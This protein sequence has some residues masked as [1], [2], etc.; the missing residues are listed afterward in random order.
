MV[1]VKLKLAFDKMWT[2]RIRMSAHQGVAKCAC[3]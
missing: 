3:G 2:K 1:G